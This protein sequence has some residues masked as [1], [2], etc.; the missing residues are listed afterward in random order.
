MA[1]VGGLKI[2][3]KLAWDNVDTTIVKR[4]IVERDPNGK[5]GGVIRALVACSIDGLRGGKVAVR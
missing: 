1:L 5:N 2:G 4:G 3:I